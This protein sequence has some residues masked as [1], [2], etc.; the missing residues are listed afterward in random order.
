MLVCVWMNVTNSESKKATIRQIVR[1]GSAQ[2]ACQYLPLSIGQNCMLHATPKQNCKGRALGIVTVHC[3]HKIGSIGHYTTGQNSKGQE[4][5][6]VH[7]SP[8]VFL[9]KLRG[10]AKG[11]TYVTNHKKK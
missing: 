6:N 4:I 11:D 7:K 1:Q 8:T 5:V 3:V 9:C 10:C 2:N